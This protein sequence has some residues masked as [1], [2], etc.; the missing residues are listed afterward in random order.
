MEAIS[1]RS[2]DYDP[3]IDASAKLGVGLLVLVSF[4]SL[5][6]AARFPRQS[7]RPTRSRGAQDK[8]IIKLVC[9]YLQ[10]VHLARPELND[11]MSKRLFKRYLKTLDPT[12]SYFVKK[13]IEE[14][15]KF[16]T[17]LDDQLR[18]GDMS[19]ARLAYERFLVRAAERVK[20]VE[21]L[22]AVPMDLTVKEFLDTDYDKM[23]YAAS[24]Q[25]ELRGAA[26]RSRVKFGLHG[27]QKDG[28]GEIAISG[29]AQVA[30][31]RSC[32]AQD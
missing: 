15:S 26:G 16:E 30:R 23:D 10:R 5:C 29:E 18:K 13:D 1:A 14:F 4:F 25:R 3:A 9:E 7:R 27:M 28:R 12:K 6:A 11:E 24:G 19:F 32:R 31:W 21:E 17:D 20:L 22:L 8:T 2:P